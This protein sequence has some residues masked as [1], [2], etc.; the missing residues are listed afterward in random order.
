[1]SDFKFL[2][3]NDTVFDQQNFICANWWDVD[4]KSSTQHYSKN[5][6]F[7]VP[8]PEV[9]EYEEPTATYYEYVYEYEEPK[10]RSVPSSEYEYDVLDQSL[11]R[12]TASRKGKSQDSTIHYRNALTS[13]TSTS[14]TTATTTKTSATTPRTTLSTTLST[15]TKEPSTTTTE[16]NRVST[17]S[18]TPKIT[19]LRPANPFR[20]SFSVGKPVVTVSTS[21]SYSSSTSSSIDVVTS[22]S[23]T[24]PEISTTS[25]PKIVQPTLPTTTLKP[26]F[27][28]AVNNQSLL[29]KQEE[30]EGDL[31]A[32]GRD[33]PFAH[34]DW[35]KD[36]SGV[37]AS[38][39][40]RYETRFLTGPR[41]RTPAVAIATR[42]RDK[43]SSDSTDEEPSDNIGSRA[44]S[45]ENEREAD[46]KSTGS[47]ASNSHTGRDSNSRDR[48]SFTSSRFRTY[49]R[50]RGRERDRDR[51]RDPSLREFSNF[52]Y[53]RTAFGN[54]DSSSSSGLRPASVRPE[55]TA[56]RSTRYHIYA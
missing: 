17:T 11:V 27:H 40:T 43:D 12:D 13:T 44:L 20:P 25:P 38:T 31:T 51:E 30:V 35:R 22:S 23:K 32:S 39:K 1:I 29:A 28:I 33:D 47:R 21:T 24:L 45:P 37:T 4:C 3:P 56:S 2:C 10:G 14:T 5:D 49:Q 16:K 46:S 41:S 53:F 34:F 15:T 54:S 19:T 55:R 48:S 42:I 6:V 26:K 18:T 36:S 50:D 8:E 7:I 9:E 52:R